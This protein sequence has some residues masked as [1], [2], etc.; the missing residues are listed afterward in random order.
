MVLFS[1]FDSVP[2]RL[3]DLGDIGI[4]DLDFHRPAPEPLASEVERVGVDCPISALQHPSD[5]LAGVQGVINSRQDLPHG[6]EIA[7]GKPGHSSWVYVE[8]PEPTD[9]GQ[10]APQG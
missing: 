6:L 7:T 10:S 2:S 4:H 8:F 5:E 9:S 1:S 3:L